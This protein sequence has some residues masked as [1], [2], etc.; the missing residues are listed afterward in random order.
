VSFATKNDKDEDNNHDKTFNYKCRLC[1]EEFDNLVDMQ[2]HELACHVQQ[3]N[4][5]KE[6]D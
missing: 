6:K 3:G 1:G 2:R 5:P 4:V